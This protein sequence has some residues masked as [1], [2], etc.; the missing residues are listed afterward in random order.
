MY[1]LDIFKTDEIFEEIALQVFHFQAE[2]NTVYNEYL[3]Y[4][5]V[6]IEDIDS[7]NKI[8]FLPISFFKTHKVICSNF[9]VETI[10]KSSGTG[11]LR[12]THYVSNTALYKASFIKNFE[13][14]YGCLNEIR[15]L[16]LLPSYQ[17]N[18]YSSLLFMVDELIAQ[19]KNNGSEYL[20]F[21]NEELLLK[22]LE[23]AN[24]SMLK[25]VLIGVTFALLDLAEK[26]NLDL[27]N[28][29]IIETG[30]MK[31][32]RKEITRVELHEI[33]KKRFKVQQIHSEYGMCELLS[34]AYATE[35]EKFQAPN[36]MKVY[37]RPLQEPFAQCK[38]GETG[39]LKI[40]DLANVYSC[41][42]IETEDLGIVH[43]DGKFEVL[44]RI[45]YAALRGCNLMYQ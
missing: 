43:K 16:A 13:N 18:K 31:G 35:N 30:G 10:F 27:S 41:S 5:D 22:K 34:Q 3:S 38:T 9:S 21:E 4:L 39:V 37:T 19:T 15:L 12:S 42:F 20:S 44:G 23:E 26:Y 17:E 33:L 8:P 14:T 40:I 1:S 6:N 2:N 7:I 32:R 24:K 45:D 29:T 11:N 25:V 36:W 28:I